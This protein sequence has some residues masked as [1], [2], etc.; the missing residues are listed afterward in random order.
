MTKNIYWTLSATVKHDKIAMLKIVLSDAIERTQHET[1]C[2]NYEFWFNEDETKIYAFERY[3]DPE[4]C[5]AHIRNVGKELP[6]FFDCVKMDPIIIFGNVTPPI[7]KIFK[8]MNATY[9]KFFKGYTA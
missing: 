7:E 2:L 8:K 3:A 1:G 5:L 9:V 6:R 4:S